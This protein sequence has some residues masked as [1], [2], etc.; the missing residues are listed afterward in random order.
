MFGLFNQA[1]CKRDVSKMG[2]NR[3]LA[4]RGGG[5]WI[6]EGRREDI[7]K[8]FLINS[9]GPSLRALPTVQTAP[10]IEHDIA[11]SAAKH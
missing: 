7:L 11:M 6:V 4:G 3:T 9:V 1:D 2:Q 8:A 5:G 10:E